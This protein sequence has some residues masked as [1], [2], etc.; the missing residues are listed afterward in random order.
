MNI[1]EKYKTSAKSVVALAVVVSAITSTSLLAPTAAHAGAS[2]C[3]MIKGF[4]IAKIPFPVPGGQMCHTIKGKGKHIK[5]QKANFLPNLGSPG[6]MACNWRIDFEYSK[7][8]RRYKTD[9]GPTKYN[10]TLYASR[11]VSKDKHLPHYGKSCAK[12]YFNNK[13]I[14]TQCHSINKHSRWNPF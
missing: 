7:G 4:S 13:R 8:N 14:A 6:K 2:G 5:W 12:L 11:T 9:R 1:I 3:Q 10:C